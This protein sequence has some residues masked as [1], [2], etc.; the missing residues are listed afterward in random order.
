MSQLDLTVHNLHPSSTDSYK[1]SIPF[2]RCR[3]PFYSFLLHNIIFQTACTSSHAYKYRVWSAC[4]TNTSLYSEESACPRNIS[5]LPQK[6]SCALLFPSNLI[7]PS[8]KCLGHLW[9]QSYGE[10]H[11]QENHDGFVNAVSKCK[12]CPNTCIPCQYHIQHEPTGKD[13]L[14]TAG[15]F[16]ACSPASSIASPASSTAFFSFRRLPIIG[17]NTFQN[18]SV[19]GFM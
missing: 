9:C 1:C 8:P 17:S 4:L 2:T 14:A 13:L 3:C 16:S 7:T 15:F 6:S 11:P 5:L 12:L 18:G 10:R 19:M